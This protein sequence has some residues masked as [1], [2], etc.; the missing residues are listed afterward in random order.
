MLSISLCVN[1]SS[2]YTKETRTDFG[3]SHLSCILII[4]AKGTFSFSCPPIPFS[5][6]FHFHSLSIQ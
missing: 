5:F 1:G 2:F 3:S 4:I 6:H